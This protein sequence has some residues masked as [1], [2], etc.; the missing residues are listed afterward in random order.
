MS[1]LNPKWLIN[2][3]NE[4]ES[5]RKPDL[6]LKTA[7]PCGIWGSDLLGRGKPQRRFKYLMIKT[8]LI[9]VKPGHHHSGWTEIQQ[10][11]ML[12]ILKTWFSN[13]SWRETHLNLRTLIWQPLAQ[14]FSHSAMQRTS[15]CFWFTGIQSPSILTLLLPSNLNIHLWK[16]NDYNRF[17]W[18]K[19]GEF[20]ATK[21]LFQKQRPMSN[22][23]VL[24]HGE[25]GRIQPA[26]LH[27]DGDVEQV[28]VAFAPAKNG[29][30][31][32][33]IKNV[34]QFIN[35]RYVLL[36]YT[37]ILSTQSELS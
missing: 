20:S 27:L 19:S 21:R 5:C 30:E 24:F 2:F 12:D 28:V 35:V 11:F 4:K 1:A 36:E 26:P 29:N 32:P 10:M 15:N 18:L 16:A 34:N 33:H 31:I 8:L 22:Y 37:Q 9:E 23:S 3:E 7:L 6:H 17:S 13:Q 25:G 14:E